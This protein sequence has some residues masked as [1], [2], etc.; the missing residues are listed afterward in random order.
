MKA[1]LI[2]QP[3]FRLTS[4]ALSRL[5]PEFLQQGYK[6]QNGNICGEG[7]IR[8]RE[9]LASLTVF[10]TVA[11]VH[12]AT[13]PSLFIISQIATTWNLFLTPQKDLSRVNVW[14]KNSKST[15]TM[16]I[17][18][19]LKHSFPGRL[20]E[21]HTK[22]GKGVTLH[23]FCSLL[24][25]LRL[26]CFF[27]PNIHLWQLLPHLCFYLLLLRSPLQETFSTAFQ[28]KASW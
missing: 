15:V 6:L 22:N 17:P 24:Y 12:Y 14:R 3:V 23:Q 20:L 25:W 27:F 1:I 5:L 13:S 21:G 11:L 8:T 7:E 26:F 18:T 19:H 4:W 2:L 28:Q 16:L 9:G 10:K